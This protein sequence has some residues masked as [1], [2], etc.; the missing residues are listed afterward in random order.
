VIIPV[1][2]RRRMVVECLDSLADQTRL[3]ASVAVVDDGSTDGSADAVQAWIEARPDTDRWRLLRLPDNVGAARARNRGTVEVDATEFI[4]FLDS[5][6][7]WPPDFLA[8]AEAVLAAD[9]RLVAVTS[10]IRIERR[11][12]PATLRDLS[13]MGYRIADVLFRDPGVGS[14]TVVRRTALDAAGGYPESVAT[15]H[16]LHLYCAIS[17][18]GPWSHL[19]GGPIRKR[20][21]LHGAD[22]AGHLA[23]SYDDRMQRWARTYETIIE[24]HGDRL[25][26][27]RRARARLI[28]ARWYRAGKEARERGERQVA[29]ECLRN[30]IRWRPLDLRPRVHLLGTYVR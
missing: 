2:N 3:P 29:R 16:D 19:P 11:N 4:A 8:R 27:D 22:E 20:H 17:A 6:D 15:G 30:A 25:G 10:D 23:N 12:A 1:F 7:L 5:D 28:G 14:A 24:Q 18:L 9:P 13:A 21:G 26:L